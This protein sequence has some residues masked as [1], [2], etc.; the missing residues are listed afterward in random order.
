VPDDALFMRHVDGLVDPARRDPSR[1]FLLGAAADSAETGYGWIRPGADLESSAAGP[2]RT[3]ARFTEKPTAA[4]ARESLARGDLWSTFVMVA[5]AGLRAGRRTLPELSDR[6]A[7]IARYFGTESETAA[8]ERAYEQTPAAGFSQ[9]VLEKQPVPLAVLALP[10]ET[11]SDWG[12][13]GRVV[14]TLAKIGA[15]PDWMRDFDPSIRPAPGRRGPR[16]SATRPVPPPRE[17]RQL[18]H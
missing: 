3:V 5:T 17:R 7:R 9:A 15:R 14:E 4:F 2:I 6:L 12:T 10:A 11:W 8:L 18:P 13:P 16:R 1:I